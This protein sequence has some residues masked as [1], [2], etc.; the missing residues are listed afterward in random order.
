[1]YSLPG[2]EN[3]LRTRIA[4]EHF[5]IASM[6]LIISMHVCYSSGFGCQ[7]P[8]TAMPVPVCMH[9]FCAANLLVVGPESTTMD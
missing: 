2:Y 1:M 6:L 9:R 8:P 5:E 3:I 7:L 4:T